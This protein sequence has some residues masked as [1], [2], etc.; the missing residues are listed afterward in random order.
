MPPT[1]TRTL[2]GLLPAPAG[3]TR[4]NKPSYAQIGQVLSELWRKTIFYTALYA[5]F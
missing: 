2:A 1:R 3:Q 5:L 4:Q